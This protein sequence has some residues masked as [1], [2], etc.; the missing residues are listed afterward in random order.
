MLYV[1]NSTI[2]RIKNQLLS[3]LKTLIRL[4]NITYKNYLV[5]FI[6][7]SCVCIVW[8]IRA[9]IIKCK[10]FQE[11]FSMGN[12]HDAAHIT[13]KQPLSIWLSFIS[14]CE[15]ETHL[16]LLFKSECALWHNMNVLL[17]WL[18][19]YKNKKNIYGNCPLYRIYT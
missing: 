12:A 8:V 14:F 6:F 10:F 1:I 19:M 17:T 9:C 15:Y 3:R 16:Y 11:I 18:L 13:P 2:T 7:T 5:L 4:Y